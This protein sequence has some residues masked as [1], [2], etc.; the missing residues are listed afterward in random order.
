MMVEIRELD[1]S[2]KGKSFLFRYTTSYHYMVSIS[3]TPDEVVIRLKREALPEP[4]HKS[5]ESSLFSDWLIAPKA[6]GVFDGEVL[7]GFIE[8]SQ[9][10]WNNRLRIANLWVDE[11]HRFKG[12][13]KTLIALAI[14]T[15]KAGGKRGLVLETQSCNDLAIRFYQSCGFELIGLDTTHYQNDDI[16]RGEVRLEFGLTLS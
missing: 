4:L 2:W 5:F 8:L 16:Q 6:F 15:A 10:D 1:Q 3:Q 7:L 13:G 11:D 14:E 9:E 12:I